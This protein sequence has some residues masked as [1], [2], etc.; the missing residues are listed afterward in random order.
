MLRV[1]RDG[2]ELIAKRNLRQLKRGP[3]QPVRQPVA[4][5]H[6]LR[7]R[8]GVGFVFELDSVGQQAAGADEV[9]GAVAAGT[10]FPVW[11]RWTSSLD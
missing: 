6:L 7:R 8:R 1:R 9:G 10:D 5:D 4:H 2:D 11:V 3:I